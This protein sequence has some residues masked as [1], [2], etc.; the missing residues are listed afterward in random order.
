MPVAKISEDSPYWVA[1]WE[2]LN[3]FLAKEG[4]EETLKQQYRVRHNLDPDNKLVQR[5][6]KFHQ[7]NMS[8][9]HKIREIF[10][11]DSDYHPNQL[12]AKHHL[13]RLGL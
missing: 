4:E 9:Y 10:G 13:P 7:D 12:A 1:A 2:S 6:G 11:P 5:R 3:A 8:K